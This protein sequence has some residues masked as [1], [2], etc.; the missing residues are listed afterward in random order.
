MKVIHS[1]LLLGFGFLP[2]ASAPKKNQ[3]G[4]TKDTYER[5]EFPLHPT[6]PP[7]RVGL[8]GGSEGL[9]LPWRFGSLEVG[10]VDEGDIRLRTNAELP[11]QRAG[12]F[13]VL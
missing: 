1:R 10:G 6:P 11:A 3:N 12:L 8:G 5:N 13:S 2:L 7:A 9:W 4:N